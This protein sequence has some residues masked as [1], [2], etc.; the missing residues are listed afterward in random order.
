MAGV[1]ELVAVGLDGLAVDLVSP[2]SIVS[3][4]GN[5]EGNIGILGPLEGFAYPTDRQ[6]PRLSVIRLD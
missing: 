5:G 4:G 1:D 6:V 3:D 2:A